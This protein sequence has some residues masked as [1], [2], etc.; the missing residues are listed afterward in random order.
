[1]N[2]VKKLGIYSFI[3]IIFFSSCRKSV[4][5]FEELPYLDT[6]IH[7]FDTLSTHIDSTDD[8]NMLM[9][10]LSNASKDTIQPDNYLMEKIYYLLSYNRSRC[11]PNWVSR[12]EERRVGKE[13]A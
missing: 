6:S 13:C 9:G 1:M 10:N 5:N 8:G 7:H 11:I 4:I 2:H 3:I 12:S